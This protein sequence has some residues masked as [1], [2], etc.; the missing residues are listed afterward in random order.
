MKI[1]YRERLEEAPEV[2][3]TLN[4]LTKY[5]SIPT[6]HPLGDR[7]R[8]QAGDTVLFDGD[9]TLT[10]KIDGTNA[11]LVVFPDGT[12]IVGS[13]EELLWCWGDLVRT[14]KLG[15]VPTLEDLGIV[16]CANIVL[17]A[18][19]RV[20]VAYG[21][22]YGHGVGPAARRYAGGEKVT[23]FRLFD[24][25]TVPLSHLE[26]TADRAASWRD[27]YGQSYFTD[28]AVDATAHTLGVDRVPK[29]GHV[30]AADLPQDL[31]TT[32]LWLRNHSS[33]SRAALVAG[34][35]NDTSEGIV[36]RGY[37]ETGR[38]RLAKLRHEDY[39]RTLGAL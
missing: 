1:D 23:G 4:S 11:R 17:R 33:S 18:I 26:W 19:S 37:D 30:A 29:L 6:Y 3:R 36:L 2:L 9:V 28:D 27:S 24:V 25:A 14:T 8:L 21:E 12:T 20:T 35:Q 13:R 32:Q 16:G 38:R 39:R 34:A 31:E 22:V 5:P 7:G 15:I 10:E